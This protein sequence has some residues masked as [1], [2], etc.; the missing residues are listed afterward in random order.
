M[1]LSLAINPEMHGMPM[2]ALMAAMAVIPSI[3][4]L[5]ATFVSEKLLLQVDPY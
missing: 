2:L 3:T 1:R 4:T 5:A